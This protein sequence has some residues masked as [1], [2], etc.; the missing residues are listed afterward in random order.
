[1]AEMKRAGESHPVGDAPSSPLTSVSFSRKQDRKFVTDFDLRTLESIIA[2]G[3]E[4][5][6]AGP[7]SKIS[8]NSAPS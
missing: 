1:M 4:Q 6:R 8:P 2:R 7:T 3:M 5:S